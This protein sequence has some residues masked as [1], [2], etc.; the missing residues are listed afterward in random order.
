VAQRLLAT[1]AARL[2]E[3][4][5]YDYF[6]GCGRDRRGLN[7]YGEVLMDVRRRLQEEAA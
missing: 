5:A 2:V 1:G 4:N 3:S 7:V 6:W